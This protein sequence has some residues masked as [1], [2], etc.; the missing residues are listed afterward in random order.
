M[1]P[2]QIQKAMME[3]VTRPSIDM[4][5]SAQIQGAEPE[6][7]KILLKLLI[8]AHETAAHVLREKLEGMPRI[9]A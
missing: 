4:L 9:I 5:H 3:A 1:T 8:N 6:K 2:E 7:Q